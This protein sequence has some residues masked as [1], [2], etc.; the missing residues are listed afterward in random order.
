[1]DGVLQQDGLS[2]ED[3]QQMVHA[4]FEHTDARQRVLA[5]ID[6]HD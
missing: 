4:L 6:A 1:M 5:V 2:R 3:V